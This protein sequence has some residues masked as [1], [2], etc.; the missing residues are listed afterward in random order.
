MYT[1]ILSSSIVPHVLILVSCVH[2][3]I[4]Q[5]YVPLSLYFASPIHFLCNWSGTWFLYSVTNITLSYVSE[6]TFMMEWLAVAFLSI[7]HPIC[8]QCFISYNWC[9]LSF[10]VS[11]IHTFLFWVQARA[12]PTVTGVF[13]HLLYSLV[14]FLLLHQGNDRCDE[15][16]VCSIPILSQCHVQLM[17]WVHAILPKYVCLCPEE[18]SRGFDYIFID[19]W[20]LF[21]ECFCAVGR[22][23]M[24]R[25]HLLY[26]TKRHSWVYCVLC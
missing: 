3:E 18:L 20:W 17:L 12:H 24:L 4:R 16:G 10:C 11:F 26:I 9:S 13:L 6:K 15:V 19:Q 5:N 2:C 23:S 14:P 7:H 1:V 21:I 22:A 25:Y 8:Y